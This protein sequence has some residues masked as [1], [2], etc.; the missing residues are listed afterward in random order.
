MDGRRGNAIGVV[1]WY[2]GKGVPYLRQSPTS[3]Q[4]RSVRDQVQ[5]QVALWGESVSRSTRAMEII[6]KDQRKT[7][8]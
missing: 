7:R 5:K 6:R 8:R 2:A 4:L 3:F 1:E